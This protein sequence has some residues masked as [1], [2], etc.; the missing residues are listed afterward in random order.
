[1]AT[2]AGPPPPK[3][4]NS[5]VPG[6]Y[7]LQYIHAMPS[8]IYISSAA[9]GII[10]SSLLVVDLKLPPPV[11][12][13]LSRTSSQCLVTLSPYFGYPTPIMRPTAKLPFTMMIVSLNTKGARQHP[14]IIRHKICPAIIHPLPAPQASALCKH[15]NIMPEDDNMYS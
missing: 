1:M 7:V 9:P 8:A 4:P 10:I 5:S 6:T 13:N 12:H 2:G 11:N 14:Y 3:S 15:N